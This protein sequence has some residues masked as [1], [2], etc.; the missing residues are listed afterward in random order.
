MHQTKMHIKTYKFNIQQLYASI[1]IRI[2]NKYN[3][4]N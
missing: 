4:F 2:A 3:S 1:V